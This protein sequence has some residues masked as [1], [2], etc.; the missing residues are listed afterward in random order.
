MGFR[1]YWN[2]WFNKFDAMIVIASLIDLIF[3]ENTS[4]TALRT[5]RLLRV[6]KLLK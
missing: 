3:P 2:D 4:F 5:F 1:E 6:F